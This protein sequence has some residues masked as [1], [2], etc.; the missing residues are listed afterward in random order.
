MISPEA[1]ETKGRL[2]S[3]FSGFDLFLIVVLILGVVFMFKILPKIIDGG[4]IRLAKDKSDLEAKNKALVKEA[5]RRDGTL[6]KDVLKTLIYSRDVPLPDRME[7][8]HDYFALGG[9][10]YTKDYVVKN[11]IAGGGE[12][13]DQVVHR[14]QTARP[15]FDPDKIYREILDEIKRTVV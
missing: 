5:G 12:L 6:A 8:A 4:L 14:K 9:N 10:G 3:A 13:W 11:V 15:D 2:L 7:A 1:I